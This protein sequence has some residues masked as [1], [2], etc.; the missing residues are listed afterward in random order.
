MPILSPPPPAGTDGS[1]ARHRAWARLLQRTGRA[2]SLC[3]LAA[4]GRLLA[5][6]CLSR[7]AHLGPC[8]RRGHGVGHGGEH[9]VAGGGWG[10]SFRLDADGHGRI[11]KAHVGGH[12]GRPRLSAGADGHL[13][14]TV[15]Q[16]GSRR[17][18]HEMGCIGLLFH[19]CM[20]L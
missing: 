6:L 15:L 20:Q 2:H 1:L 13:R 4:G 11:A 19:M 8:T 16:T 3:G 5:Q 7:A 10:T 18:T 12:L 9:V 17:A 14:H